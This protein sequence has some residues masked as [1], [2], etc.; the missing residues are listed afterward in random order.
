MGRKSINI[1]DLHLKE[2]DFT[3]LKAFKPTNSIFIYSCIIVYLLIPIVVLYLFLD[4]SF[5]IYFS[6]ITLGILLGYAILM[7]HP[8]TGTIIFNRR[9]KLSLKHLKKIKISYDPRW[10]I[11]I[12][13]P[14]RPPPLTTQLIIYI[15]LL[16]VEVIILI[17]ATS[18]LIGIIPYPN[19]L[20][21]I[22]YAIVFVLICLIFASIGL[23]QGIWSWN[24]SINYYGH[25]FYYLKAILLEK[26]TK[27]SFE[28]LTEALSYYCDLVK[29]NYANIDCNFNNV[30]ELGTTLR[31]FTP[32]SEIIGTSLIDQ[33]TEILVLLKNQKWLESLRKIEQIESSL[34]QA[35]SDLNCKRLKAIESEKNHEDSLIDSIKKNFYKDFFGAITKA[36]IYPI[37]GAIGGLVI[38]M[39][40]G[41]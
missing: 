6:I 12:E 34:E 10:E 2:S 30:K 17:N 19:E 8:K 16:L 27:G 14:T 24:R 33:L 41:I 31:F 26:E 4:F 37:L 11:I 18:I 29:E 9:L 28:L 7:I 22:V 21:F 23:V 38:T 13:K 5:R 15:F 32:D 39:I 25:S 1:K 20:E 35:L 3:D 40:L 36:L